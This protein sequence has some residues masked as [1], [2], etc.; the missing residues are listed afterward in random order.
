MPAAKKLSPVRVLW[1]TQGDIEWPSSRERV[2]NLLPLLADRGIEAVAPPLS[3]RVSARTLLSDF[4]LA[5][6]ADVVFIQ[7]RLLLP[8]Y[9]A[10]LRA[11]RPIVYDFDD[12]VY[13]PWPR[14]DTAVS[15]GQASLNRGLLT[16]TLKLASSVVAG[17]EELAVRARRHSPAVTVVPTSVKLSE[18]VKK[19]ESARH[20]T[21][22]W[23]GTDGNLV[24]LERM[25]TILERLNERPDRSLKLKIVCSRP[26]PAAS[27]HF[28]FKQWSL[29]EE[30]DDL[31]SFDVGIMPLVDN[32]WARGK[33]GFKLLQYASAGLPVVASPVGVNR[34]IVGAGRSGFLA[35]TDDDWVTA[36]ETLASDACLRQS[37]GN[38][39]RDYVRSH[40]APEAAADELS[41]VIRAAAAGD[42]PGR[43][44]ARRM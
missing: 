1:F 39:G 41:E 28:E 7:K 27:R 21:L 43:N 2:F 35:E 34:E 15:E 26:P 42:S 18:T 13:A 44:T 19:H 22:G 14:L 24:Y 25:P 36:L 38:S 8:Q 16:A 3:R 32:E 33:C 4:R 23:I 9:V 31:L 17:N 10:L 30:T 29:E 40:Y 37:M 5:R 11:V 20:L 12:A 6:Q